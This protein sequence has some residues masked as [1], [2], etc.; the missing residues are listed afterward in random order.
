MTVLSY[1]PFSAA[2]AMPVRMFAGEAQVWEALLSLGLLAGTVVLIV[3]L[4]SRLY[5]GSLLQT[6]GGEGRADEG[7][8]AP[9]AANWRCTA[10]ATARSTAS[11]RPR[12]AWP[13]TASAAVST[14]TD[15]GL[16]D[17]ARL[18]AGY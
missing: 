2:V 3:L 18:T 1:V 4:A 8:A 16:V 10:L 7:V 6:R 14:G 5:S 12:R 17:S 15:H 13:S 11:A 9:A